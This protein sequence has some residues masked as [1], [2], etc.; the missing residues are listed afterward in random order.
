MAVRSLPEWPLVKAGLL[1]SL[2]GG[3]TAFNIYTL[4]EDTSSRVPIA[5]PAGLVRHAAGGQAVLMVWAQGD[6]NPL[7]LLVKSSAQQLG[8]HLYTVACP[9]GAAAVVT[10][11]VAEPR[12]P[13]R[14]APQAAAPVAS[15]TRPQV[16]QPAPQVKAADW[17]AFT[18][19]LSKQQWSLLTAL[20][21]VPT[22]TAMTVFEATL[23]PQ[24]R[25]RWAPIKASMAQPSSATSPAGARSHANPVTPT[26]LPAWLSWQVQAT[27]SG[28]GML[29]SY[30]LQNTGQNAVVLDL[31]R[32]KVATLDGNA[33]S[34]V[35]LTRQ[36]TSGLEGRIPPGGAESGVIRIGGGTQ[37]KVIISWPVVA[38]GA[39]GNTYL[40]SQTVP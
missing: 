15:A 38:V 20:I 8:N 22:A 19:G 34:D 25:T 26:P 16:A 33:V 2:S 12:E 23:T 1:L 24:Q 14:P 39:Q 9:A 29:V 37:G 21:A 10:P 31:A 6:G 28:G 4:F 32:L 13:E 7:Q 3:Y 27:Q 40:V 36:D 5:L 17:D 35:S 30:S 18:K 11:T